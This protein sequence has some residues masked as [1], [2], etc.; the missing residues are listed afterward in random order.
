MKENLIEEH[1]HVHSKLSGDV[2]YQVDE[3]TFGLS[4]FFFL[5][6]T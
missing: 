4:L 6:L 5:I 1:D 2:Q 3:R